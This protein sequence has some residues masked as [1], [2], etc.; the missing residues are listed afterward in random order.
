M[1]LHSSDGKF[2]CVL[3]GEPTVAQVGCPL[4]FGFLCYHADAVLSR[5]LAVT[6]SFDAPIIVIVSRLLAVLQ[7]KADERVRPEKMLSTKLGVLRRVVL[8]A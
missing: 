6:S 3:V 8:K 7:P 5:L 2:C 1:V 4:R